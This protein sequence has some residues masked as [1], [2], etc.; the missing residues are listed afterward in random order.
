M[1]LFDAVTLDSS[2]VKRTND[3]FLVTEARVAR[4]GI[5][6]YRRSDIGLVG[7]GEI[8]I[9]RPE[10]EVFNVES[11]RSFAHRPIT[12]GHP[13]QLVDA[14]N[15]KDFAAGQTGG[16]VVREGQFVRVPL[17]LMDADAIDAVESGIRELSMGYTAEIEFVDGVTPDGEPFDAIQKGL[18][19]NHLAVVAK[20]RGGSELKI[21][22][23]TSRRS[24]DMAD[25]IK[26]QTVMVDG[27]PVETTS[28][29]A[30]VIEKLQNDLKAKEKVIADAETA[31]AEAIG[32]KDKEI[33]DK[34]TEIDD[35]KTKVLDDAAIDK[36]AGERAALM[37]AAR[38]IVPDMKTEGLSDADI[39]KTAVAKVLGDDAIKDKSDE[40]IAARFDGLSEASGEHR[41][42]DPLSQPI[43]KPVK[44]GGGAWGDNVFSSAG[45]KMKK[46]A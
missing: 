45:V 39:R 15:W 43:R 9:F 18:R 16:Q 37:D 46:E 41:S 7:D 10:D 29:G 25:A 8:R 14:K 42:S 2:S 34:D 36:R 24:S 27:L 5:Q 4:T 17:V 1:Q 35:L 30:A 12:V 13:D 26:T 19:M 22:D 28:A 31:H 44:D 20:A 32:K 3:G 33:A 23:E 21:G 6:V 40:Y 11:L 38:K